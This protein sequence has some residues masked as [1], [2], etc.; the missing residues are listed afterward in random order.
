MSA[1]A[2]AVEEYLATRRALGFKLAHYD[3]FLTDF[4]GYLQQAGTD[5]VTTA[6]AVAWA[7]QPTNAH[8]SWW[9]RRLGVIRGFAHY[10]Q[11]LDPAHEVPPTDLLP[12]H[13]SP[14]TPY[15]YSSTDIAALLQAAGRLRAPLQAL[16]YQTLIGLLAVTG[17]RIGEAC[18]LDRDDVDLSTGLITVLGSKFGKSRQVPLHHSTVTALST[19]AQRRDQL[20]TK[21]LT[22]SFFVG[23]T[24]HRV[25]ATSACKVF[26]RLLAAADIPAPASQRRPRLHDLRHSFAV[27]TLLDWYRTGEDVHAR[28]PLLSTY[29]GHVDPKS[30]YWYLHAAPELLGLAAERLERD[31]GH[32]R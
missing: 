15:L 2:T 23:A 25:P 11:A 8:P 31:H 18:R 4:L 14:M 1:L 10:L 13:V 26:A 17:L 5:T 9:N 12:H 28:L 27:A 7:R 20:C 32:L 6:L 19:Y 24:H 30:T 16:T 29:L 22:S 21:P 3:R